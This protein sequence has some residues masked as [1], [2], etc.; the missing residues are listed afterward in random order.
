MRF[1]FRTQPARPPF[2][3][4]ACF[5]QVDALKAGTDN[6][7]IQISSGEGDAY[8]GCVCA[9]GFILKMAVPLPFGKACQAL[10]FPIYFCETY[11]LPLLLL[12]L[13]LVFIFVFRLTVRENFSIM[14]S[15]A[16][17]SLPQANPANNIKKAATMP[18]GPS[19]EF[20]G[21]IRVSQKPPSC[22]DLEKI[23]DF[24]VLD[25][26]GNSRTFKSLHHDPENPN[27][28]TLVI[29]IR[30]FFC[31]VCSLSSRLVQA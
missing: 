12:V 28:R 25:S 15:R 6:R 27:A 1:T 5:N 23:A 18:E 14:V 20:S 16:G 24:P 3:H 7:R 29:F 19:K 11:L 22:K 26:E 13:I 30:H 17:T 10:F 9:H 31:G 21:S 8:A 4:S 2:T